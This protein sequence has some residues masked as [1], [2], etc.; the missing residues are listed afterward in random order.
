MS[1]LISSGDIRAYSPCFTDLPGDSYGAPWF[2][3]T[4]RISNPR[5]VFDWLARLV[6]LSFGQ[7][8]GYQRGKGRWSL[9]RLS[10]PTEP[11][12]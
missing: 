10:Q 9:A 1:R 12:L 11:Y 2:A 8:P 5:T 7:V 3:R 6:S 4:D